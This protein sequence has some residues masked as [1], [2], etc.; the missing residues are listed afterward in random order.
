MGGSI[1]QTIGLAARSVSEARA[2][3]AARRRICSELDLPADPTLDDLVTAVSNSCGVPIRIDYRKLKHPFTGGLFHGP[4]EHLLVV[5]SASPPFLRACVTGH[6][7]A[8]LY[9][10]HDPEELGH[11]VLDDDLLMSLMPALNPA[12]AR[13]M[14]GRTYFADSDPAAL[15][16]DTPAERDA[17]ILGRVMIGLLVH[18]DGGPASQAPLLNSA[19][20]HRGTG[21]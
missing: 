10:N 8:H 19:L 20:R 2:L 9:L 16:Q 6:E 14:L 1:R 3:R 12:V 5:D 17:E 7:L 11:D 15:H 13:R 18:G 4:K 21:V